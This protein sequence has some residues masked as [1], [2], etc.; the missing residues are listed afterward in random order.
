[1]RLMTL[2]PRLGKGGTV[3]FDCP[4]CHSHRIKLDGRWKIRGNFET[5]RITP[6]TIICKGCFGI[7][8]VDEGSI[9]NLERK[10]A[11]ERFIA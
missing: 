1:M 9:K 7:F 4:L 8:T 11:D 6:A 2:N 10:F 3:S 5:L